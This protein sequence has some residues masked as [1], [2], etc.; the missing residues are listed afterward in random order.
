MLRIDSRLTDRLN[1][2]KKIVEPMPEAERVD[3]AFLDKI[4][5]IKNLI[6]EVDELL[7]S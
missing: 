4:Q 2:I 7:P 3:E 1:D 5:R 6:N